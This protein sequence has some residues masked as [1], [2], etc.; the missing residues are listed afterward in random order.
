MK[1]DI[2]CPMA[3]QRGQCYCKWIR[4]GRADESVRVMIDEMEK[5]NVRKYFI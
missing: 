2:L 5:N 1:H 4:I 3:V